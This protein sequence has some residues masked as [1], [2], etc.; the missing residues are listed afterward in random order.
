[1]CIRDRYR[2]GDRFEQMQVHG[3][4]G[5]TRSFVK[6]QDGCDN[7]CSYCIIPAARGPVRSK[8]LGELLEEVDQLAGAGF[9]E[10]VLVGINPVS[11]THLDVYKRQRLHCLQTAVS[12]QKAYPHLYSYFP[13]ING[14]AGFVNTENRAAAH[15]SAKN[16]AC[17]FYFC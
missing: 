15:I 14:R 2:A 1:M 13:I 12:H 3:A 10:V 6:I 5:R 7:W 8:P 4:G 11:Y 16:C 9:R 17:N